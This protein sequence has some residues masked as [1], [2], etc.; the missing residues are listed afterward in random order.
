MSHGITLTD[1]N[2]DQEVANSNVPVLVDYWAPWC[3]PC[4]LLGPVVEQVAAERAGTLK[5]RKV[6][7]D[8]LRAGRRARTGQQAD[9]R[10]LPA[11]RVAT[12]V[13]ADDEQRHAPAHRSRLGCCARSGHDVGWPRTCAPRPGDRRHGLGREL[14]AAGSGGGL[15]ADLGVRARGCSGRT[16]ARTWSSGSGRAPRSGRSSACSAQRREPFGRTGIEPGHACARSGTTR[17][18]LK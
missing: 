11:T 18:A 17:P 4:R 8:E 9:R 5:V 15:Q 7:V 12:G 14:R 16:S 1:A 10:G 13:C 6:N 2:F 3:G